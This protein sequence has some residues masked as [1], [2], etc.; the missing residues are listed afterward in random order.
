MSNFQP[1]QELS[2]AHLWQYGW[3]SALFYL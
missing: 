2:L 1:K 3:S